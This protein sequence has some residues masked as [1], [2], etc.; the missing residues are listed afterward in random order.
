MNR[1]TQID[2]DVREDQVYR[3][4][5]LAQSP[6]FFQSYLGKV[7]DIGTRPILVYPI[8]S[9]GRAGDL[10]PDDERQALAG[11]SLEQLKSTAGQSK[12]RR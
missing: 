1:F 10:L 3:D 5:H 9:Q 11:G 2:R 12:K 6:E 8:R 4:S 7:P